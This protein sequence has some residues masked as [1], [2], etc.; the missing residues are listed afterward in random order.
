[1]RGNTKQTTVSVDTGNMFLVL[2]LS[3][4]DFR[5]FYPQFTSFKNKI[6]EIYKSCY[7]LP[8]YSLTFWEDWCERRN[9]KI[10]SRFFLSLCPQHNLLWK[11]CSVCRKVRNQKTKTIFP[12]SEFVCHKLITECLIYIKHLGFGVY[13]PSSPCFA[14]ENARWRKWEAPRQL[15]VTGSRINELAAFNELNAHFKSQVESFNA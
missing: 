2:F 5:I 11:F 14:G 4:G 15:K 10:L 7:L 13:L 9:M 12:P 8:S 6:D 3:L 1:M